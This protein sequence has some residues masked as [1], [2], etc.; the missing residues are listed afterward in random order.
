MIIE[1]KEVINLRMRRAWGGLERG[2]LVGPER[3]KRRGETGDSL[4][5]Q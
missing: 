2:Y 5:N 3:G 4:P 1:E